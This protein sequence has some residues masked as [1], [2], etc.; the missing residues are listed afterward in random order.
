M[1]DFSD[2]IYRNTIDSG[3]TVSISPLCGHIFRISVAPYSAQLEP[4][5]YQANSRMITKVHQLISD[6]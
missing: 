4:L 6:S 5:F 1:Y 2:I 3:K